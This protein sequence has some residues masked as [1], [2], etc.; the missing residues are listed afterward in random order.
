MPGKH[1]IKAIHKT[2]IVGTAH[3]AGST[4]VKGQ[5]IFSMGNNM[6]YSTHCKYRTAATL[7]TL[8]TW[9]FSGI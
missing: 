9:F 6:K 7:N 5:N 3:T 2:A 1:G 4:N 8:Q